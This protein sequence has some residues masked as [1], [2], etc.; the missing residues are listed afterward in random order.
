MD[1]TALG[2]LLPRLLTMLAL[3]LCSAFFSGSETSLFSL[4]RA[5]RERLAR[6]ERSS[7]RYIATLLTEPRR[8]IV[9]ILLGN[10]LVNITFS[11]LAAGLTEHLST[12]MSKLGVTLLTAGVTVPVLLVVGEITPKSIALRVAAPWARLAARPLGLFALIATPARLVVNFISG[13]AVRILS[14]GKPPPAAVPLGAAE[15][16]ALVDAGS[17][18]GELEAA[19]QRLIHKVF[20]FGDRTVAEIMTPAKDV[21]SISYEL[22]IARVV[23][24]VPRAKFSRIPVYRGKRHEIV[25]ILYAKDL[26]GWG[27]GRLAQ[28]TLKDLVKPPIYVPKTTR[29]ATVFQE[30]RKRRNHMALVVDEYGRLVGVV[31]ME[32][33]LGELFGALHEGE[34]TT[35][36]GEDS[37]NEIARNEDVPEGGAVPQ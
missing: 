10:E 11:S 6:S 13:V 12:G 34:Q 28:R 18:E 5:Q 19:E 37:R 8:L 33:L 7:D 9:T 24:E 3:L 1:A 30:F 23:A 17:E 2:A 35:A 27:G 26:V 20:E 29:C 4:T 25:G 31:T 14:G 21:F 36:G 16:R 32:D 15:F 22:P